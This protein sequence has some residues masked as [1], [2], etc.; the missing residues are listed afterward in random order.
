MGH[1][2]AIMRHDWQSWLFFSEGRIPA[3]SGYAPIRYKS[4]IDLMIMKKDKNFEYN[5]QRKL[6][7]LDTEFNNNNKVIAKLARDNALKFNSIAA[8]LFSRK[9]RS[10]IDN[11]LSKL[12]FIDHQQSKR[13][14]FALTSLDIGG[15]YNRI[16]HT[17]AALALLR[18]GV[19][20]SRIHS[21]FE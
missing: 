5:N 3:R 1:Y 4:C 13:S 2:K 11:T 9:G 15:C 14:C 18:I 19:P 16:I 10:A 21:I 12:L 8:D 20:K 6:G 17:V 7:I